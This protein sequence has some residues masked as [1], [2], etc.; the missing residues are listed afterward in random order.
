MAALSVVVRSAC[1]V[2]ALVLML[3][4][5][6][7]MDVSIFVDSDCT[8]PY[9]G[10][11]PASWPH[12]VDLPYGAI[13]NSTAAFSVDQHCLGS[14]S[15]PPLPSS[16]LPVQS[17]AYKCVD[18]VGDPNG[19]PTNRQEG[20]FVAV[21]WRDSANCSFSTPWLEYTSGVGSFV[22]QCIPL[23][24]LNFSDPLQVLNF[25]AQY[26]YTS[27]S[28]NGSAAVL[29]TNGE[30]VAA[31]FSSSNFALIVFATIAAILML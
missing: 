23:Q 3:V 31:H 26:L 9:F 11:S 21:E 7:A 10:V 20:A 28:C 14:Y 24:I 27:F 16:L 15:L 13:F 30:T 29:P 1:A 2:G 5:A 12:W 8:V 19:P 6:S 25:T 4:G 18:P 22:G 17:G